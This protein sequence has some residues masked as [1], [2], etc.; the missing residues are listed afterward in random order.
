[1]SFDYII[2]GAGAAGCVLAYRLSENPKLRVALVEAGPRDRHP[3]IAMPKGLAKVIRKAKRRV[4]VTTF[5][6]NVARIR[7]VALAAQEA[8]RDVVVMGRSMQ[9]TIEVSRE[10]GYLDDLPAFL[11]EDAYGYL[12][13]E[14]VVLLLTGSQGEE[15]AALARIAAGDHR[16]VALSKGDMVIFS[17]RTIPGN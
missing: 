1:M 14:R 3:F 17:S 10:L 2:C 5:A 7:S 4:A 9:R 15:R 12:P 13:P 8:E 6:S 11:S 16:N